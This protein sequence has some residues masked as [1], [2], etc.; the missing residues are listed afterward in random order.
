MKGPKIKTHQYSEVYLV[1]VVSNLQFT[2]C[3][4][5]RKVMRNKRSLTRAFEDIQSLILNVSVNKNNYISTIYIVNSVFQIYYCISN[6]TRMF[7]VYL[8]ILLLQVLGN[9]CDFTFVV[10]S[11]QSV[12]SI[13][14]SH[15]AN[16][17]Q[18]R[19]PKL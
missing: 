9:N 1:S 16:G 17:E 11:I 19:K 4:Q 13:F 8:I 5:R 6:Y 14:D 18:N 15:F 10:I 3:P 12:I 2:Y 7:Q